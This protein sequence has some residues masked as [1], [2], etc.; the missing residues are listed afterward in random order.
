MI[1][2]GLILGWTA[3][4]V[5]TGG[6]GDGLELDSGILRSFHA[7]M[8]GSNDVMKSSL[9]KRLNVLHTHLCVE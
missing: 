3:R 8:D 5:G 4:R 7:M 2:W 9:V 1:P 6:R